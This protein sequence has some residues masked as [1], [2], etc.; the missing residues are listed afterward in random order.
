MK[1]FYEVSGLIVAVLMFVLIVKVT[2]ETPSQ[3]KP[4]QKQFAFECLNAKLNTDGTVGDDVFETHLKKI[5][6]QR[7]LAIKEFDIRSF[8]VEWICSVMDTS[9]GTVMYVRPY[10]R[11]SGSYW[12]K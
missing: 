4:F 7:D 12:I 1:Y 9:N 3:L 5:V 6:E 11:F 2:R 10:A 8:D